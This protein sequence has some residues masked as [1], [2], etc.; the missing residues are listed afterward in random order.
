MRR[1]DRTLVGALEAHRECPQIP[2]QTCVGRPVRATG[3]FT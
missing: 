3:V 2:A 1:P